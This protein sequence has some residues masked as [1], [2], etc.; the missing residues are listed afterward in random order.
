MV[1]RARL[2]TIG[3]AWAA[4]VALYAYDYHVGLGALLVLS[5]LHVVLEFPLDVRTLA[6]LATAR[7]AP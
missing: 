5:V 2:A 6:A 3:G 1:T 7:R 4:A